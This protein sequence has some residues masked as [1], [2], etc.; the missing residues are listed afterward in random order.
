[1]RHT[2]TAALTGAFILLGGCSALSVYTIDLPQGNPVDRTTAEK[3]KVGMTQAQVRYVLGSPLVTDTLHPD[4]WDYIYRF[5]PG[6]YARESGV[7]PVTNQRL[8]VF[9]QDGKVARIE[10]IDTLPTRNQLGTLSR[11]GS[12]RE[13]PL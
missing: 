8:T 11:D 2:L 7:K 1:M 13:E 9:F 10:G 4:R 3:L 5:R 6:T 12:L